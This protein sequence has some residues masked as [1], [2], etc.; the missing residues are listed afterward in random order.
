MLGLVLARFLTRF[1]ARFLTWFLTRWVEDRLGKRKLQHDLAV[2][3]SDFE[4]R[5]QKPVLDAFGLQYFPNHRPRDLPGT[6]GIA[7]LFAFGV[8]DQFVPDPGVEKIAWHGLRPTLCLEAPGGNRRHSRAVSRK[9]PRC[10]KRRSNRYR[11]ARRNP[12]P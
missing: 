3:V 9:A 8:G 2:V 1:L 12:Q 7:Q 5:T 10:L 11:R 6:I 4:G